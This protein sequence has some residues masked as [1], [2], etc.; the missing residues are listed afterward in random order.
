MYTQDEIKEV[1]HKIRT[2][3]KWGEN[4]F[5]FAFIIWGTQEFVLYFT[6]DL[7][8]GSIKIERLVDFVFD[9]SI[10]LALVLYLLA[11]DKLID[12]HCEE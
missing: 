8:V 9:C 2:I 7:Q 10:V 6:G 11:L 5:L 3:K 1:K 12:N 4:L